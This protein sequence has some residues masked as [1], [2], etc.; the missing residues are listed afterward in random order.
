MQRQ[1]P[2]LGAL[3]GEAN[4]QSSRRPLLQ[5]W[6]FCRVLP[7][8]GRPNGTVDLSSSVKAQFKLRATVRPEIQ[9]SDFAQPLRCCQ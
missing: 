4:G 2:H 1:A 3:R 6:G 7:T 9:K 5:K 8:C